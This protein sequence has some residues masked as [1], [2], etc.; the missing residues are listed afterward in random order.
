M[1]YREGRVVDNHPGLCL[2]LTDFGYDDLIQN[3]R[4]GDNPITISAQK[5]V[6]HIEAARAPRLAG[7]RVLPSNTQLKRR[8]PREDDASRTEGQRKKAKRRAAN[9]DPDYVPWSIQCVLGKRCA[10][11][12]SS[13]TTSDLTYFIPNPQSCT[14][15]FKTEANKNATDLLHLRR[16]GFWGGCS[17]CLSAASPAD[18]PAILLAALLRPRGSPSF[19][20]D[21][22]KCLRNLSTI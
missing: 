7:E 15:E 22:Q 9:E 1:F 12:S 19:A 11:D 5:L 13:L 4:T 16:Q 17:T 3:I 8:R 14:D 20:R 18:F 21:Q 6:D 10:F 2:D